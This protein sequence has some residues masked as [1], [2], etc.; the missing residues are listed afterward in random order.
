MICAF[1]EALPSMPS[2]GQP[3]NTGVLPSFSPG[4]LI[5]QMPAGGAAEV[6]QSIDGSDADQARRRGGDVAKYVKIRLELRQ[7]VRVELRLEVRLG[8]KTGCKTGGKTGV[9]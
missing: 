6:V 9:K 1:A 5:A 7:G 2:A 3:T 8:V 4:V